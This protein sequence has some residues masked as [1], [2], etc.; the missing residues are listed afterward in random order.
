VCLG[1]IRHVGS[2]LANSV[3][4]HPVTSRLSRAETIDLGSNALAKSRPCII[5]LSSRCR[6][7]VLYL[8]SRSLLS[9]QL[10]SRVGMPPVKL[11]RSFSD[12]SHLRKSQKLGCNWLLALLAL[13][14]IASGLT[15]GPSTSCSMFMFGRGETTTERSRL[16]G[17]G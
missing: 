2:K 9:I 13:A 10:F 11:S 4:L 7:L 16:G 6:K 1:L 5:I 17:H 14:R 12:L 8:W 3:H 15:N